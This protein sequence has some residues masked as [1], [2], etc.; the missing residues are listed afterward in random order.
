MFR[1]RPALTLVKVLILVLVAII[2]ILIGVLLPPTCD[3]REAARRNTCLNNLTQIGLALQRY[4]DEHGTLPP[5]YTVDA[6]GNRLHSWRTLILPFMEYA[7]LYESIDLSKP[8]DDPA[9][10]EARAAVV[11]VYQCP[12]AATDGET[13]TTY[14]A[15]V[16]PDCCFTGAT[17]RPPAEVTDDPSS[18]LMIVDAPAGQAVD[19]M[20]PEDLAVDDVLAYGS[21]TRLHHPG[22]FQGAFFDGRAKA[23][24][25]ESAPGVRRAMLT[26]AG[27][28]EIDPADF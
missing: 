17:S 10:A 15:V 6:E 13:K 3:S 22:V 12:S 23:I 25:V 9:N 14:L 19:W 24:S 16:G 18:T 7:K 4:V 1:K 28:E 26:V 20:S 27:G 2:G 5:A 11:S 8:W 21:E